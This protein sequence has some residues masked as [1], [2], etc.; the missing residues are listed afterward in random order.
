ML[1]MMKRDYYI[2]K[3]Y[4]LI[5]LLIFP[6]IYVLD[7]SPQFIYAGIIVGCIFNLF[8][9]DG[10][11]HV[12][13]YIVSLPVNR[14]H[15]VRGRYF[16]LFIVSVTF[17]VYLWVIDMLAHYFF[18]MINNWIFFETSYPPITPIVLMVTFIAVVIIVGVSVPIYYFFQSI[19]KSWIVQ[20]ALL[21]IGVLGIANF[22]KYIS[23]SIVITILDIINIQPVLIPITLTF[24]GFYVSYKLS[25]TIFAKRDIV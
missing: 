20:S 25:A 10:H 6:F 14:C 13:R 24:T 22:G 9:Y 3:S 15:I 7:I 23:E 21:F 4:F 19:I 2:N 17:L 1:Q 8:Y 18:P 16:F 12:S 5:V 11:N